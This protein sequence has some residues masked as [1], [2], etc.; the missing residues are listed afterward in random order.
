[1][2]VYG[3]PTSRKALLK[4]SILK[5]LSW[6]CYCGLATVCSLETEFLHWIHHTALCIQRVHK[7][8]DFSENVL[9]SVPLL[10]LVWQHLYVRDTVQWDGHYNLKIVFKKNRRGWSRNH[11]EGFFFSHLMA[12]HYPA[13]FTATVLTKE[14]NRLTGI[15][16]LYDFIWVYCLK[17]WMGEWEAN[18]EEPMRKEWKRRMNMRVCFTDQIVDSYW[19]L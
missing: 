18:I 14:I 4:L 11:A 15:L 3:F 19:N 9:Y 5:N 1:M 7:D 10:I 17:R 2:T 12:V 16:F 6:P 8:N 13:Y